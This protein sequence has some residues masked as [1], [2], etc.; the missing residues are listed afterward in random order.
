MSWPNIVFIVLCCA[1]GANGIVLIAWRVR[2]IRREHRSIIQRVVGGRGS[3]VIQHA[4]DSRGRS[5]VQTAIVGEGSTSI[6][7]IGDVHI[8]GGMGNVSISADRGSVA[9]LQVGDVRFTA[10]RDAQKSLIEAACGFPL[11]LPLLRRIADLPVDPFEAVAMCPRC[12]QVATHDFTDRKDGDP[13]EASVIRQCG[14]CG[15]R[16]GQK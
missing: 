8:T 4:G 1:A 10:I 2:D 16:W 11:D 12:S 13:A 5:V 3:T 9:A 6:Q 14:K 15:Q 7:S